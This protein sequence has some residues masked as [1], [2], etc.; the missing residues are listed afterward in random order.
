MFLFLEIVSVGLCLVDVAP[1]TACVT[2]CVCARV[3]EAVRSTHYIRTHTAVC[4]EQRVIVRIAHQCYSQFSLSSSAARLV[5]SQL[6]ER[7]ETT[8]DFSIELQRRLDLL[9]LKGPYIFHLFVTLH[10]SSKYY[11]GR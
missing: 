2:V 5:S 7:E 4:V 9:D 6:A 1:L 10:P 3:C 8:L 11:Q